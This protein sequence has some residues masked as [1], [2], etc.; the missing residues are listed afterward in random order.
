MDHTSLFAP[1]IQPDLEPEKEI[2]KNETA[3]ET[4]TARKHR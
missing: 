3:L 1:T 4:L 2:A